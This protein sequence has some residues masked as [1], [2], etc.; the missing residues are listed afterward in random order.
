M[1]SIAKGSSLKIVIVEDEV[2]FDYA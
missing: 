2:L 1:V